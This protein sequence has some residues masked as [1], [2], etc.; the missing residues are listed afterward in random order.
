MGRFG[1]FLMF[2]VLWCLLTSLLFLL[3]TGLFLE[4]LLE[5]AP[6]ASFVLLPT[7]LAEVGV[8]IL[9]GPALPL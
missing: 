4:E 7:P 6:E 8:V 5:G 1:V 2:T 3:V 9:L